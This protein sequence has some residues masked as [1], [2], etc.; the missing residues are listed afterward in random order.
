[1]L[2]VCAHTCMAPWMCAYMGVYMCA[3][4]CM[5]CRQALYEGGYVLTRVYPQRPCGCV[6]RQARSFG[7]KVW[8]CA[9]A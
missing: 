5:Y 4:I 8:I 2:C 6:L 9:Q 1:M 3:N 7:N